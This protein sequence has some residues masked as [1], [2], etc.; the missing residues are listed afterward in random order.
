MSGVTRHPHPGG[1]SISESVSVAGPGTWIHVSGQIPIGPDGEVLVGPMGDQARNCF[2]A[3]DRAL[4]DAGSALADIVKI[5][6]FITDFARLA[7][8]NAVRAELFDGFPASTAVEVSTLF[9]GAELEIEA[10]AFKPD[11]A[12]G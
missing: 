8:V 2:E 7:E 3:L 9:G 5:T 11:R 1:L 12:A 6:I 4:R 10:V